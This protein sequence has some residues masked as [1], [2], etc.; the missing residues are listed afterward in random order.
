MYVR[1]RER[2]TE[3]IFLS[4]FF[5]PPMLAIPKAGPESKP[6]AQFGFT[7]WEAGTHLAEPSPL[8]ST[9]GISGAVEDPVIQT[10][11]LPGRMLVP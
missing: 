9:A 11:A 6:T 10:Q 8:S 7:D 3:R 2:E 5:T 4:I 1:K